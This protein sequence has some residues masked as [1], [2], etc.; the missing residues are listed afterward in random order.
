[1]QRYRLKFPKPSQKGIVSHGLK[2]NHQ[3]KIFLEVLKSNFNILNTKIFPVDFA[4][5]QTKLT[6][7]CP[8]GADQCQ[9]L[10]LPG[11]VGLSLKI[12]TG[13]SLRLLQVALLVEIRQVRAFYPLFQWVE[14]LAFLRRSLF[15]DT[16]MLLKGGREEG[17]TADVAWEQLLIWGLYF[18]YFWKNMHQCKC[19]TERMIS[20]RNVFNN[21][22]GHGKYTRYP[23]ICETTLVRDKRSW[24]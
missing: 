12:W 11:T 17:S 2:K 19:L 20:K 8:Y 24:C 4:T 18:R 1:M 6:F 7:G 14:G 3:Y 5:D 16:L 21:L 22:N 9:M 23:Q 10:L 13:R 15:A